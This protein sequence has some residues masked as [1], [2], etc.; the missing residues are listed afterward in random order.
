MCTYMHTSSHTRAVI[1]SRECP[2]FFSSLNVCP[3]AMRLYSSFHHD[4]GSISPSLEPGR[5]HMR[6]ISKYDES[7]SLR[8]LACWSITPFAAGNS[9]VVTL[10]GASLPDD[11]RHVA[12]TSADVKSTSR[13]ARILWFA[14]PDNSRQVTEGYPLPTSPAKQAQTEVLHWPIDSQACFFL[15]SLSFEVSCHAAKANIYVQRISLERFS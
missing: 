14:Q 4:V 12:I 10:V 6:F 13:H 9:S 7:R 15:H 8:G 2:Q 3:L 11:E 1:D 5:G